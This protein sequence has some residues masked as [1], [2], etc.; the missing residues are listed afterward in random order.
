M[1]LLSHFATY[2]H[3]VGWNDTVRGLEVTIGV[4]FM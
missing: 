2:A 3:E 4:T 1:V